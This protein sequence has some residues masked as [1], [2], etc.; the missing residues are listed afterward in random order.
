MSYTCQNCG[1][2]ADNPSDLCNPQEKEQDSKIC[3]ASAVEVCQGSVPNM[4]YSCD[5]C[6]SVSAKAE[7][8]CSPSALR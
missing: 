6:G 3:G 7:H 8:L 2:A 5:A 1:L 4:Q